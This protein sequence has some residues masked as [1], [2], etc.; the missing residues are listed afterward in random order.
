VC[1]TVRGRAA[2]QHAERP[3]LL[4]AET[5]DAEREVD[6]LVERRARLKLTHA[7]QKLITAAS[8]QGDDLAG[9]A[10]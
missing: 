10:L 5:A 3:G 2:D 9:G 7:P 8:F 6:V 4:E 1:G